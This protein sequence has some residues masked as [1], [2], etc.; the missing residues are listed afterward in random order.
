MNE[1]QPPA[2]WTR[3]LPPPIFNCAHGVHP[4]L[5][6]ASCGRGYPVPI[7]TT[8]AGRLTDDDVER[9]A[10]RVVELLQ[11]DGSSVPVEPAPHGQKGET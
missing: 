8:S 9:I 7:V 5:P 10:R 3:G 1:T 4:S 11:P 2:G 6:C